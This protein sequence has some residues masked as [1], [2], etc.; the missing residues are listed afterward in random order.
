MRKIELYIDNN[1]RITLNEYE[2]LNSSKKDFTLKDVEAYEYLQ[3]VSIMPIRKILELPNDRDIIL[4]HK[5]FVLDIKN[6]MKV[7]ER[8]GAKLILSNIQKYYEHENLKKVKGKKVTRKNRYSN[9]K[10]AIIGITFVIATVCLFTKMDLCKALN[11]PSDLE[12]GEVS[13]NSDDL[14]A[15]E[16]SEKIKNLVVDTSDVASDKKSLF[17]SEVEDSN[18]IFIDYADNSDTSK[19]FKTQHNYGYLIEKYSKLYGLDS[20]LMTA[21]A[22]QERGEHS[23]VVDTGGGIGL[24]QV[25]MSVWSNQELTAYNFETN[26]YETITVDPYRLSELEYNIKVGCMIFQSVTKFFD[27]N[28]LASIQGYNMGIGS[29]SKILNNYAIDMNV[30]VDE[31]LN[32]QKNVDWL[33]YREMIDRGDR[34]YIEHVLSWMGPNIDIN[35]IKQDGEVVSLSINNQKNVKKV[36]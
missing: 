21:I 4:I 12:I 18:E 32:N 29:V 27:Y 11:A 7:F 14:S 25:Q 17:I 34:E 10:I 1:D 22:T 33:Q 15:I 13:T 19:A 36:Y 26:E 31:I 3:K 9:K 8:G 2:D 5:D 35:N 20:R 24:M 28:I 6:Y 16:L 30:S 23:S